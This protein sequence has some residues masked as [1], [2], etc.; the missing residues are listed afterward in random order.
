MRVSSRLVR[1]GGDG[2]LRPERAKGGQRR[3]RRLEVRCHGRLKVR[4]GGRVPHRLRRMHCGLPRLVLEPL[5][6]QPLGL[7]LMRPLQLRDVLPRIGAISPRHELDVRREDLG[8]EERTQRAD[9]APSSLVLSAIGRPEVE[10]GLSV[11]GHPVPVQQLAE[12]DPAIA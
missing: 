11:I 7:R 1:R 5:E 4:C 6:P 3:P 9:M 12:R 10:R 8:Q 2:F